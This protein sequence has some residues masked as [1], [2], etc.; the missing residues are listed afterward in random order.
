V[1]ILTS[2]AQFYF[3]N[4]STVNEQL[5]NAFFMVVLLRGIP[6]L[7]RLQVSLVQLSNSKGEARHYIDLLNVNRKLI[8]DS[9]T[10]STFNDKPLKYGLEA[11][12]VS[13]RHE[14]NSNWILRKASFN[15][16]LRSLIVITGST[17]VGK[18]TLF[19]LCLGFDNPQEGRILISGDAPAIARE[20]YA[21]RI[22]F[23]PQEPRIFRANI[24]QNITLFRN[25]DGNL[26]ELNNI[27]EFS[28]LSEFVADLPQGVFT[29]LREG[30]DSISGGQ[31]Q[32]LALARA[33]YSK[34][35]V[36][37][38]DEATS[39]LDKET[40]TKLMRNI[41]T[42]RDHCLIVVVTHNQEWIAMADRAYVLESGKLEELD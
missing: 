30:R 33:I 17:G 1:L 8:E 38:L 28:L 23:L 21:G 26:E 13:F 3:G 15:F 2:L 32:R 34:P 18:S 29:N 7:A 37:F 14:A 19:D 31:A 9:K 27:L 6:I 24:I 40:E 4:W 42:M 36:L 25:F 41:A 16:D 12:D 10:N 5:K 22:A 11:I 20:K 35:Q 39:A